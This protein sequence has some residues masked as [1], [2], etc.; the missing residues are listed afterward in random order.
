MRPEA[1]GRTPDGKGL[2]GQSREEEERQKSAT[3]CGRRP[4]RRW[5]RAGRREARQERLRPEAPADQALAQA[6]Q[7]QVPSM[8]TSQVSSQG[9][10]DQAWA[11][12][13]LERRP[14]EK[15]EVAKK[16]ADKSFPVVGIGASAGGLE[17]LELFF[18][19]LPRPLPEDLA[20]VIIQH[21]GPQHRSI[22]G[23]ILKKDTDL[24]VREIEDNMQVEPHTIYFNPPDKEVGLYQGVFQLMEPSQ[25]R[26]MRMPIDY[27]FRSLAQ[28]LEE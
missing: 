9:A 17:P 28:D 11:G 2:R 4:G 12:Q 21:L 20:F 23:E 16:Q 5:S 8:N 15:G 13:P 3:R 7:D 14:P 24:P 27:F 22:I 25:G 18:S 10:G 1:G 19:S 6:N 26:H